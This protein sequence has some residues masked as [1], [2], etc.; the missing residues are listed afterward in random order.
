[1][2]DSVII[3][4]SFRNWITV[5]LM[6]AIGFAILGIIITFVKGNLPMASPNA[7]VGNT[8]PVSAVT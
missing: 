4:W 2:A 8:D 7:T 6:V 1:M 5:T 3:A